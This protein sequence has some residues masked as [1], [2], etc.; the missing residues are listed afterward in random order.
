MG[1]LR[2]FTWVPGPV[3]PIPAGMPLMTTRF[4]SDNPLVVV[5]VE[6]VLFLENTEL[7]N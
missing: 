7:K 3:L 6:F 5:V 1:T 2:C 4:L